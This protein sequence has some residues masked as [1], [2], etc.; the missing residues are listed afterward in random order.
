MVGTRVSINLRCTSADHHRPPLPHPSSS[1]ENVVNMSNPSLDPL[2]AAPLLVAPP[3]RLPVPDPNN[4]PL[5]QSDGNARDSVAEEGVNSSESDGSRS[6]AAARRIEVRF[7]IVN[8]HESLTV[9]AQAST[10]SFAEPVVNGDGID[11]GLPCPP[12]IAGNPRT[13][14]KATMVGTPSFYPHSCTH[15]IPRLILMTLTQ[16]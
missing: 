2:T 11:D 9:C 12:S 3:G 7:P 5:A 15:H 13:M 6:D 16:L 10:D 4:L 14:S 1:P 8:F